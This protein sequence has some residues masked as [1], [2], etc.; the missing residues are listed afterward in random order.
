MSNFQESATGMTSASG[1]ISAIVSGANNLFGISN[2]IM[3]YAQI[4]S[5]AASMI[6][7]IATGYQ[8]L[9]AVQEINATLGSI[10]ATALTAENATNPI[11]WAKI[12]IAVTAFTAAAIVTEELMNYT[13][14]GDTETAIG[15]SGI[16]SAI[17]GYI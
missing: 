6:S 1:S 8:A 13:I 4:A 10:K 9:L 17:G 15:R 12:A 7:G 16:I 11:G 3:K 5:S 2:E 14:K